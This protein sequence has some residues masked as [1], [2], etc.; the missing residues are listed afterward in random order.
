[1]PKS[2]T[3]TDSHDRGRFSARR[4]TEAVLRLLRGEDLDTL[5]RELGV[6]AAT[7]SGWRDAL[8]RR[9]HGGHEEP[10]GRRAGRGDRPPPGQGRPAHDGQRA[11][12]AEVPAP[13]ERPPFC[14]EEAERLARSASPGTGRRYGL[15]RVCRIFGLARST[16]YYLKARDAVPPERRPVPRKRPGRGGHRR[17]A[18]RP[19]P[20]GPGR[21]A[22]HR[23]FHRVRSTRG[24]A[25]WERTR[26]RSRV[27]N[28]RPVSANARNTRFRFAI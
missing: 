21:V 6:T 12:G 8:P 16:A 18:G 19:H 26:R 17:R 11:A 3:K 4:K 15:Q 22:V 10:A 25:H 23:S 28:R 1:M 13:G 2:S 24:P 14:V 9:R 5:S 27:E 7:L 20:P